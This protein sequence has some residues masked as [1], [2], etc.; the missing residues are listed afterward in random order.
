[1]NP[2]YKKFEDI[3]RKHNFPLPSEE[4]LLEMIKNIEKLAEVV[5]KFEVS[6]KAEKNN[7]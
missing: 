2:D 3:L 6:K 1:M 5:K 4:E 7:N